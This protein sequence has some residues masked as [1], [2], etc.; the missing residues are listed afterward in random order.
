MREWRRS[1]L[2]DP[3]EFQNSENGARHDT[4]VYD[5]RNDEKEYSSSDMQ[6][7]LK[8]Q[9]Q[10]SGH[11]LLDFSFV[12]DVWHPSG[13]TGIWPQ[14]HKLQYQIDQNGIIFIRPQTHFGNVKGRERERERERE[15]DKN[16]DR[17]TETDRDRQR[18][19]EK[20]R[21][22]ARRPD[23]QTDREKI[24]RQPLQVHFKNNSDFHRFVFSCTFTVFISVINIVLARI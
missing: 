20:S 12:F 23:N 13:A 4:D 14:S 7:I 1:G 21:Q 8:G 9:Y 2:R 15:R 19:R 17:Q 10:V 24:H 16:R 5:Y 6:M 11:D 3:G 18:E 22:R